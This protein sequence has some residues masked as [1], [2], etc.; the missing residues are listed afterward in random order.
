[1][2]KKND[3]TISNASAASLSETK[4]ILRRIFAADGPPTLVPMLHG[5]AGVGKTSI[6]YQ[7]QEELGFDDVIMIRAA[8]MRPEDVTG[9]PFP[10]EKGYSK[11]HPPETLIKLTKEWHAQQRAEHEKLVSEGKATGEY[12]MPGKVILFLDEL[13]NAHPD[14]QATLHS[15]ILDRSFG[16]ENYHLL[17]TVYI[18]A[19]GNRREDG[20]HVYEL[21][22]PMRTRIAPHILVQPTPEEWIQWA[23][24]NKIHPTIIAFLQ[25]REQLFHDYDK[26]SAGFTYPTY[27]TWAMA[28]QVLKFMGYGDADTGLKKTQARS[29]EEEQL[30][31]KALEGTVGPGATAEFIQFLRVARKAPTAEEIAKNP[32]KL[33][34]FENDPDIALVC[35]ENML[36]AARRKPE[37]VEA[38]LTYGERMHSQY[39]EIL[40]PALLNLDGDMPPETILK[41]LQSGKFSAIQETTAELNR[42]LQEGDEATKQIQG[43]LKI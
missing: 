31:H 13:P 8:E 32:E 17:D 6:V 29:A 5:P 41:V 12:K 7:L 43:Q 20:A 21:S 1:M 30:L 25:H 22:A 4:E 15:L 39:R 16:V 24:R 18:I 23:R 38:F 34:T 2:A 26:N 27:R 42:I 9:P 10:Y 35:V 33:D 19:A 37:W 36:A 3:P 40:F 28:S 11:F 14:I